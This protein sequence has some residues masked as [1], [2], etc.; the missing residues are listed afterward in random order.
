MK[1][2]LL[3]VAIIVLGQVSFGQGFEIVG[4]QE[5]YKG[6]IGETI[7]APVRFKNTSDKPIT[8][9]IRKVEGEIGSSQRNFFCLDNSCL[10]QKIEDYMLKVEP[11]QTL[12]SFQIALE[13][14]LA[15]GVVSTV[16]YV[17]FNKANPNQPLEFQVNFAVEEKVEKQDVYSSRFI[18]IHDVYPNP[19][20]DNTAFVAYTIFSEQSKF[21]IVLHNI[22]GNVVGEY[23]LPYTENVLRIRTDDMS[24][25]I[26]FYTVYLEN[27]GLVTRKM[28][29]RKQ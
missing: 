27:E 17:V 12:N 9:I 14:G 25:G 28:I 19:V 21:K 7:K 16:R 8:L 3:L 20:T 5:N 4:L 15:P 18:T 26:Y 6:V 11:G 10:D 13:A 2:L 23:P 1:K 29:V 24:A 22:L